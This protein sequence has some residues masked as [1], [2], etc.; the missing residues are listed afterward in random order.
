MCFRQLARARGNL[1]LL[2][3]IGPAAPGALANQS[4]CFFR[5]AESP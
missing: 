1:R 3:Q 5:L 4:N 2:G